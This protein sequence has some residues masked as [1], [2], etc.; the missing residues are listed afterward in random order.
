M[1]EFVFL[2]STFPD[3]ASAR[4][5]AEALV[6]AKLAACVNLSA[7]MT[8]IYEWQGKLE[9]GPEIAAFIKT[10]RALVDQAIA[11]ARSLH[12]YTVP[13]FLILPIEGG[14]ADY[15]AWATAQTTPK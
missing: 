4:Y 15:L 7:P 5:V 14:S 3:E 1:T 9:T 10:R 8:S 2:Y 6:Q 12:P 11:T 13:C